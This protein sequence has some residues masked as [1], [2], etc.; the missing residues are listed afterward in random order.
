MLTMIR[1]LSALIGIAALLSML[2]ALIWTVHQHRQN[3]EPVDDTD[4]LITK[5]L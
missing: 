5:P 2:A 4:K 3:T 1:R